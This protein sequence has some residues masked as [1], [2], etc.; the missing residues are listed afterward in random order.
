MRVYVAS[1][2][3]NK[4]EVQYWQK[5]LRDEGVVISLDWTTAES[6][7]SLEEQ[8]KHAILDIRGVLTADVIW[9]IAPPTGGTG[10]WFEMGLAAGLQLAFL[11]YPNA[12]AIQAPQ[13]IVSGIS[14]R[15]IFTS[16]FCYEDS[17]AK[18]FEWIRS[19]RL[20]GPAAEANAVM[21]PALAEEIISGRAPP[22]PLMEV[23]H[24]KDAS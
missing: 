14:P 6:T 20:E 8:R 3:P 24:L 22:I 23:F 5:K 9:I 16:L 7:L 12:Q 21:S 1:P 18:A 19:N 15:N 13:I 17:H 11:G 10:V 4:Q 2:F